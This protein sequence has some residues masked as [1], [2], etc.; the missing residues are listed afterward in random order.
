MPKII[1]SEVKAARRLNKEKCDELFAKLKGK[2]KIDGKRRYDMPYLQRLVNANSGKLEEKVINGN[3]KS[4]TVKADISNQVAEMEARIQ[5]KFDDQMA[6]MKELLKQNH[7]SMNGNG[8]A[9]EPEPAPAAAPPKAQEPV[10]EEKKSGREEF[11]ER[12]SQTDKEK[13]FEEKVKE[14]EV[15]YIEDP[16]KKKQEEQ[17]NG[18]QSHQAHVHEEGNEKEYEDP[19]I[20]WTDDD[21]DKIINILPLVEAAI[22]N[23]VFWIANIFDET[24]HRELDPKD[25]PPVDEFRKKILRPAIEMFA[26]KIVSAWRDPGYIIVA[27]I[28]FTVLDMFSFSKPYIPKEETYD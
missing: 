10:I 14:P 4:K 2:V 21:L 9:K 24:Y 13:P 8:H 26:D 15:E 1:S 22:A 18:Q 25:I 28:G 6:E 11:Y 7:I 27:V 19:E 17:N 3:H 5:E 20:T 16:A 23:G 12:L